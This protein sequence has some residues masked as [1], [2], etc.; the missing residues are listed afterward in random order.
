MTFACFITALAT[1]TGS[2]GMAAI[3]TNGLAFFSSYCYRFKFDSGS[4]WKSSHAASPGQ[5]FWTCSS[6]SQINA[7]CAHPCRMAIGVIVKEYRRWHFGQVRFT[8]KVALSIASIFESFAPS[9][10]QT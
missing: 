4:I 8:F 9:R 2:E 6:I 10:G 1:R 7:L 5:W 3:C